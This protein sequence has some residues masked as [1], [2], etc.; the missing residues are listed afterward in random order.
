M[1]KKG[2]DMLKKNGNGH[3]CG[4]SGL[5]WNSLSKMDF[6]KRDFGVVYYTLVGNGGFWE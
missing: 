5:R 3:P 1:E 4:E 2:S 6:G